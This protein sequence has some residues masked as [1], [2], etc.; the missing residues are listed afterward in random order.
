MKRDLL[1]VAA[2]ALAMTLAGCQQAVKPA[3]DGPDG[4]A[5]DPANWTAFGRTPGSQHYSPLDKVNT[6]N[7]AQLGLAWS[8]DLEPGHSMTAPVEAGGVVFVS[9]RSSVVNALDAVTGQKLWEY[10]PHAPE[11]AG[12]KLRRAWGSRG[13]AYD[14]GRVFVGTQDGRLIALDAKTGKEAWS[15]ATGEP[16]D[17]RFI[18]GPPRP[19]KGKVLIG[20]GGGDIVPT[21]GYVTA[22]DQATGKQ[23]WRFYTVPGGKDDAA[24]PTQAMAA[25]TWY[26]DTWK[27][28]AGGVVWHAMTYDAELNR[29]YLGT[30]NAEPYDRS[31]R[32]EGQG[33]NLF[34]ASIVALDADTGK[35]VWHYQVNPGEEW[36]FDAS[37]DMQLA[38][39]TIGGQP[40]K[41]LM[42]QPKNGFFY[43]LDRTNGKLISAEPFAKVNWA[44]K[45]DIASGRPVENPDARFHGKKPFLMWP[46]P[47]GAHNW[48][49]AAFSPRTNLVY[50]PVSD[51]AVLWEDPAPDYLPK[52]TEPERSY[53]KAWDPVAQKV[54]WQV[55]TPGIWSGGAIATG[56]DLVF[57]GQIDHKFNAYDAKTGKVLWTF[58]ARAPAVSPPIT[59]EVKG[60]QYVTVVTGFGASPSLFIR[61]GQ[62]PVNLDYRTMAR[63]V[64]TFAIGGKATL[65]PAPA[66]PEQVA[67]ADPD[68]KPDAARAARGAVLFVN[69]MLC[70]GMN[71]VAAGAAPD[72]RFS[73]I[74]VDTATF[75]QVVRDGAL[76]SRGMPRFDDLTP[77]Q[78]EDIRFYIRTRSHEPTEAAGVKTRMDF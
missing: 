74:P 21:R 47:T 14:A 60:V 18:T 76:L 39:L 72:L 66:A 44:T 35:Y 4:I 32:S 6:G 61:P 51:R 54:V 5:A 41:V 27:Q 30:G 19:F 16:G 73:P 77:T 2:A 78:V 43:V 48:L 15:V 57:Q 1:A 36:D 12:L 75:Q 17:D 28:G 29:V 59:Y 64:L 25:K 56:G 69:C 7:V 24:D 3:G 70:H 34:S 42:Q 63:R 71:A 65:P 22:Y 50:I 49:P 20:H 23:L 45:I 31:V 37:N 58:D 9:T 11:V 67:P 26:G 53:L 8:Y 52:M 40:R 13:L 55:E 10:D 33:D 62:H 38:T 46:T 68:F